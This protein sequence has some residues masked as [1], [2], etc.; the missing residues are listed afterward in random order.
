MRIR[1]QLS[2]RLKGITLPGAVL[3]LR[4]GKGSH[5]KLVGFLYSS[6]GCCNLIDND[7]PVK[8]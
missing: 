1:K 3:V 5:L 4:T 7:E 6:T 8:Q 2:G